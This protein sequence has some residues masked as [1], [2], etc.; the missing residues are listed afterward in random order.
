MVVAMTDTRMSADNSI[1]DNLDMLDGSCKS[2]TKVPVQ[3]ITLNCW[4]GQFLGNMNVHVQRLKIHFHAP[5][6]WKS[7]CFRLGYDALPSLC[8]FSTVM[9]HHTSNLSMHPICSMILQI[10]A[11][12]SINCTLRENQSGVADVCHVVLN[13][14]KQQDYS[15]GTCRWGVPDKV[16]ILPFARDS[17]I[18]L[19]WRLVIFLVL[20]SFLDSD[21]LL[22]TWGL[23]WRLPQTCNTAASRELNSLDVAMFSARRSCS[24]RSTNSNDNVQPPLASRSTHLC[25]FMTE[26]CW[27]AMRNLRFDQNCGFVDPY[28]VCLAA[29]GRDSI[30]FDQCECLQKKVLWQITKL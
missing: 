9:L 18:I 23:L 2:S 13:T 30:A 22:H 8:W 19:V 7:A 3:C 6:V 26:T 14:S 24:W 25:N 10:F 15:P 20:S 27:C 16:D 21:T 11:I 17:Q 28:L 1:D 5:S 4:D 12:Y 29:T